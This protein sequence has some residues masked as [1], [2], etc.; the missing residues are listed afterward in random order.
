MTAH[1]FYFMNIKEK[2][3]MAELIC[4]HFVRPIKERGVRH[5]EVAE[6]AM[7][8]IQDFLRSESDVTEMIAH[9]E[10][11]DNLNAGAQFLDELNIKY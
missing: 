6:N 9:F 2:R 4:D 10:V 1:K 5:E 3:R 8:F 11:T 7:R